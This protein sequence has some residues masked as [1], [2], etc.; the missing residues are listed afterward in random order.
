LWVPV[1]GLTSELG[2]SQGFRLRRIFRR[3]DRC[4]EFQRTIKAFQNICTHRFNRS[5]FKIAATAP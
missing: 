1:P 2:Q 3:I 4:P 5:R